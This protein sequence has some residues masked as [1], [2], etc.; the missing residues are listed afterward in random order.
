MTDI[1]PQVGAAAPD[2][3]LMSDAGEHVRLSDLRGKKVIIYFYP[4]DATTGCIKQASGFRDN[5]ATITQ[6][7]AIVLG[8][9]PDGQASHQ[10]FKAR[11]DLPFTLLID[12]K[13]TVA[14]A[15]GVWV[16]KSNYGKTYMGIQRSHFVVDEQGVLIE[17]ANKVNPED[18]VARAI[19]A[20]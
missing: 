6:K 4:K 20:L 8:I 14:Q 1:V 16:E 2:F 15:Y 11:F 3:E 10:A 18:S 13:H 9:S 7:N 17:I 5:Y 19:A 12:D